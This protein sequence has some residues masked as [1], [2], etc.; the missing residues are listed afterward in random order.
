MTHIG[1][2]ILTDNILEEVLAYCQAQS[3]Y[4]LHIPSDIRLFNYDISGIKDKQ[5]N[6]KNLNELCLKEELKIDVAHQIIT[7]S[8][9]ASSETKT[10]I[11]PAN[12]FRKEAQNALLKVLEEP[13]EYIKFI[14]ITTTKTALLPTIRSRMIIRDKREKIAIPPFDISLKTMN[15][16]DI[17]SYIKTLSSKKPSKVEAKILVESLLNEVSTFNLSKNEL[18]MFDNAL[19]EIEHYRRTH[20]VLLPLLLMVYQKLKANHNANTI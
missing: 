15:L 3:P 14:I 7:E 19:L 11:I 5:S 2:I 8:Y 9:I 6:S 17:F 18:E 16:G 4:N 12:I 10:L 13:P 20:L 1:E